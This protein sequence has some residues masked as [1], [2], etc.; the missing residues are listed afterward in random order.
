[1]VKLYIRT[2]DG[3]VSSTTY[4]TSDDARAYA[5]TFKRAFEVLSDGSVVVQL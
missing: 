1:M 2:V 3:K 5:R 4:R